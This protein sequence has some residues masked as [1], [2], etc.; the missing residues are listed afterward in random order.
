MTTDSEKLVVG[1]FNVNSVRA[2]F[3]VLEPYLRE[4]QVDLLCL[5]ETKVRDE[6]FPV[7]F[8]EGLGY[9]VFFSGQKSYNG[10]ALAS[11]FDI[12]DLEVGFGDGEDNE[13]DRARLLRCK[14]EGIQVLNAYVPQGRELGHPYFEYKLHWFERLER[15]FER[16]YEPQEQVLLCGDLNVAPT[17]LDVHDPDG[18][19]DH[20]CFH[21]SVREA[22][23]KVVRSFGFVDLLR[24]FHPEERIYSFFDYR[25]RG[26]V[27]R[28][29][30]WRIDHILASPP[31]AD[32]ALDCWVD[33]E[34]RLVQKPS[35]H[36]IL[37]AAFRR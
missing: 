2:R 30:G 33:L 17:D 20:V 27:K 22:F 23:S 18:H 24:H 12:S 5:Q 14:V 37:L 25:Q 11:R 35:D 9:K 15:L 36:T 26:S 21:E 4:H 16:A 7:E 10:V 8:F 31:L 6:D 32:R 34:P 3:H 28:G 13:S 29:L 19:R 1:T